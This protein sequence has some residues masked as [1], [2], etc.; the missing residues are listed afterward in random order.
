MSNLITWH[1][2]VPCL[3]SSHLTSFRHFSL[4]VWL[5][6]R[7]VIWP[8]SFASF[9]L[10]SSSSFFSFIQ[11]IFKVSLR[12]RFLFLRET[13]PKWQHKK[14]TTTINIIQTTKHISSHFTHLLQSNFLLLHFA[15]H[16]L[17]SS[18]LISLFLILSHIPSYFISYHLML[19][20]LS[21]HFISFQSSCIVPSHVIFHFILSI[22]I[23]S[24]CLTFYLILSVSLYSHIYTLLNSS[25]FTS[26]W[27]LSM[28]SSPFF[29]V[30]S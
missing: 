28:S 11:Y 12:S 14:T 24:F 1:L 2:I 20:H 19:F 10:I 4:W 9:S 18:H 26:S 13:W 22:L 15:S 3:H 8:H 21:V 27:I 30:S 16:H 23:V 25:Y 6:S 17:F 7:H 5:I 29:I